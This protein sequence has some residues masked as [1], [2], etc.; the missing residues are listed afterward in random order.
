MAVWAEASGAV[1]GV[2]SACGVSRWGAVSRLH[3]LAVHVALA[4]GGGAAAVAVCCGEG[5]G[6]CLGGG[7]AEEVPPKLAR[8]LPA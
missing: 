6:G 5:G 2:G 8:F 3:G 7:G 4:V 1:R